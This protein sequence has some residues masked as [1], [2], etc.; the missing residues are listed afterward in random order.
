M[1]TIAASCGASRLLTQAS[2]RVL[3]SHL[4]P[5]CEIPIALVFLGFEVAVMHGNERQ[6]TVASTV[7]QNGL[8]ALGGREGQARQMRFVTESTIQ[9]L[10]SAQFRPGIEEIS[11]TNHKSAARRRVGEDGAIEVVS[12]IWRIE[13]PAVG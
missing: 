5:W 12:E 8:S 9:K 10:D 2:Y 7:R 4:E 1:G 3:Q 13:D 11:Q 6:C